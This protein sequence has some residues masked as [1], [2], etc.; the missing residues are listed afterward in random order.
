MFQEKDIQW[1]ISE[2]QQH[3]DSASDLIRALGERLTF[4][5]KQNEELRAEVIALRRGKRS[6]DVE[7]LSRHI[8]DF[9]NS[10]R[11]PAERRLLVY[12][13]DQIVF[14]GSVNAATNQGLGSI[15]SEVG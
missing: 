4:L 5:D 9:E 14:N 1:W 8:D 3:P 2:V 6:G 13:R 12:K 7:S 15:G 11:G 10:R